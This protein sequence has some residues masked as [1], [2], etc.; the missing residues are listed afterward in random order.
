MARLTQA[1]AIATVAV[2]L[3]IVIGFQIASAGKVRSGVTAFGVDIGGMDRDEA[4]IAL[5]EARDKRAGS[6][7]WLIDNNDGWELTQSDL[8]L[9][10]DI[11]GALDDAFEV[12]R[13]GFGISRLAVVWQFK[14]QTQV[15]SD[16]IAIRG[17]TL[18][19]R[20]E[21]VADSI[22]QPVIHPE[23]TIHSTGEYTYRNHQV[24]RDVN[25]AATSDNIIRALAT[26]AQAATIAVDETQPNAYDENYAHA[27]NQLN[28]ILDEPI[29]LVAV[30]HE[31]TLT[32]D[33][34]AYWLTV[35]PSVN[36]SEARVRVDEGWVEA[37]VYEIGWETDRLPKTPR[38]WW[39]VGGQLQVMAEGVS[40]QDLNADEARELVMNAFLGLI[41]ENR[42]EMPVA[43]TPPPVLPENLDDLGIRSLIAEASTP[44]GGG[45]VPERAHNI[46]LAASLINGTIIMPGQ[47]FSFNAEIGPMTTDAGFQIAYGIANEGGDLRTVPSEAGGICQ[48]SSTV[49]Q[50][51]FWSGYQIEVRST[52]SYWI[53]TYA[54]RGY[55]G[56]DATVDSTIGMD[57]QWLNNSSTAVLLG[58][59]A[60]GENLTIRLFGT[61][62]DWTVEVDPPEIDNVVE[63][64]QE[65]VEQEDPTLPAG[66][67]LAIERANDGFDIKIVR[68]VHEADGNVR[69]LVLETTYGPSRNVVL[70]G[71]GE[72]V[73]AGA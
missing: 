48:V 26:G 15:A 37:V 59:E 46:E 63:A 34:I 67:R 41:V 73:D 3:A 33:Q 69:E 60:D 58:A 13:E 68:R 7:L 6:S 55:A 53:P 40:G 20:I 18:Q 45:S 35:E 10:M 54:S 50:P 24:G 72:N 31:W 71:T 27:L 43:I 44:Y 70:V 38:V 9:T 17:S 42:V 51:V 36:G 1:G 16:R 5:E 49:F 61:P 19:S 23:L 64:N 29:V 2:L 22:N 56:L 25:I 39:D 66:H 21:Q 4:R 57:F 14:G 65:V 47:V 28:N 12:G 32:P 11:E 30:D 62:P 52:H 8:G